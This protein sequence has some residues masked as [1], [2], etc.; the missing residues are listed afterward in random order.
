LTAKVP[1]FVMKPMTKKTAETCA[2]D[3]DAIKAYCER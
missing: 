1:A 2:K 3:L